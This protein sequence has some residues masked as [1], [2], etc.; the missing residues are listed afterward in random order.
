M[1]KSLEGK[2]KGASSLLPFALPI[3]ALQNEWDALFL[4]VEGLH[5]DGKDQSLSNWQQLCM[6]EWDVKAQFHSAGA[7]VLIK[8]TGCLEHITSGT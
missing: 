5:A 6:T 3:Q 8:K 1:Q 2:D 7:Q 4:R